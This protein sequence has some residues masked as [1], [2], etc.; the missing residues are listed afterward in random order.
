MSI[1]ISIA[2][3]SLTCAFAACNRRHVGQSTAEEVPIWNSCRSRMAPAGEAA[4]AEVAPLPLAAGVATPLADGGESRQMTSSSLLG[5]ALRGA[6]V[7]LRVSSQGILTN[8]DLW[9]VSA[10]V[11]LH[12]TRKRSV[13]VARPR[14]LPSSLL[15]RSAELA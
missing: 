8:H 2:R 13:H 6:G 7:L 11:R 4:S 5:T 15:N 3:T 10:C 14:S 12:Q 1:T 9:K